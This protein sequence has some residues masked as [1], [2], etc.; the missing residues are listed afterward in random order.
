LYGLKQ[1]PKAWNEELGR[2][3]LSEGYRRSDSDDALFIRW[4]GDHFTFIPSW[5]DDLLLVGGGDEQV[6]EA[7]ETLQR[8]FKIKDLGRCPHT[9]A[10]RSPGTRVRDG[11]SY[12]SRSTPR[13]WQ[14]GFAAELDGSS[15]VQTPM[16]PDVL[17]K[18]RAGGWPSRE[19][20][21]VSRERYLSII[22]GLMYAATSARPRL[23][24][25]SEHSSSGFSRSQSHPHG[26]ASSSTSL[27][28]GHR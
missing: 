15:R 26:C 27:L 18:I 2:H 16:A 20:Q 4:D 5:V 19:A 3:L 6:Q 17:H 8:G 1:A 10:C 9:S 22:G 13:G 25:H 21:K 14:T 7:K 11:W 28:C 12:L 24:L 23:G